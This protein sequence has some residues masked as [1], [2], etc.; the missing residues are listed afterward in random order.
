MSKG[1]NYIDNNRLKE[2]V[3]QYTRLNYH[4]DGDWCDRYEK[5]MATRGVKKPEVLK[6]ATDFLNRRRAM[7][8]ERVITEESKKEY[9]KVAFELAV[10]FMKIATG[11]AQSLKLSLDEDIDDIKQD[12][13]Y[14]AFKYCNRYDEDNNTS[15]FAYISQIMKNAMFMFIKEREKEHLDGAIIPE[16]KLIF[17][18]R[19]VDQLEG[20]EEN[21]EN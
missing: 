11:L 19:G 14:S 13:I 8:K 4:D 16:N 18:N 6:R 20:F 7:Y 9:D 5:T 3:V 1:N 15:C 2:L 17:D 10:A 12:A 21:S